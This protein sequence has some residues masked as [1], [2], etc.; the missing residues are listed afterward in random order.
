MDILLV[1]AAL[2]LLL[3][4]V[5]KTAPIGQVYRCQKCGFKTR[6]EL[7]AAGHDKLENAHKTTLQE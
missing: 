5:L 2:I 1:V 7:E 3:V 6:S 4:V